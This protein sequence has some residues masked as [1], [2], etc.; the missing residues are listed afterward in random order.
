MT[1]FYYDTHQGNA[2]RTKAKDVQGQAKRMQL[3][4]EEMSAWAKLTLLP[5]FA[6][7][8]LFVTDL[9]NKAKNQTNMDM[10]QAVEAEKSAVMPLKSSV[11]IQ[12]QPTSAKRINFRPES[13]FKAAQLPVKPANIEERLTKLDIKQ[14]RERIQFRP[15]DIV[16]KPQSNLAKPKELTFA[17]QAVRDER[18]NLIFLSAEERKKRERAGKIAFWKSPNET[19]NINDTPAMTPRRHRGI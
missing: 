2:T 17:E 3:M 14:L 13:T 7:L 11:K 8:F 15:N 10:T 5:V 6:S 4:I 12:Q 16:L 19:A 9:L 1:S 18:G